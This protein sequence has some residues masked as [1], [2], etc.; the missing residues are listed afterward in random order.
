MLVDYGYS[1]EKY[2]NNINELVKI[3]EEMKEYIKACVEEAF[4]KSN[5]KVFSK[6]MYDDIL[7]TVLR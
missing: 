2:G 3:E 6:D 5:Y 1:F 7:K 4:K